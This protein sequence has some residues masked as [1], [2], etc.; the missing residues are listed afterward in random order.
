MA[1]DPGQ[2]IFE[3]AHVPHSGVTKMISIIPGL[4]SAAITRAVRT[5]PYVRFGSEADFRAVLG[6]Q[7]AKLAR[8]SM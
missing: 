4:L 5:T 8:L 7:F 1:E 2:N 3:Y 6:R